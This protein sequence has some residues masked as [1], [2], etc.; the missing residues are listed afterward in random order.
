MMERADD[1][2]RVAKR[3]SDPELPSAVS[4]TA[5]YP[6]TP[7]NAVEAADL[8]R[9]MQ[10]AMTPTPLDGGNLTADAAERAADPEW[11]ES[12]LAPSSTLSRR[13][14]WGTSWQ[15]N[16][17]TEKQICKE[18]E[19]ILTEHH[20]QSQSGRREAKKQ[21]MHRAAS[22]AGSTEFISPHGHHPT[23]RTKF[24]N[25]SPMCSY[26]TW[27]KR[28]DRRRVCEY[29]V[30]SNGSG[31]GEGSL[32]CSRELSRSTGC[33]DMRPT[34]LK[35]HN[36]PAKELL[37]DGSFKLKGVKPVAINQYRDFDPYS[38]ENRRAREAYK[39]A[40]HQE[41]GLTSQVAWSALHSWQ[42]SEKPFGSWYTDVQGGQKY[43]REVPRGSTKY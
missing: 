39:A 23:G 43:R 20:K 42:A 29:S 13:A 11:P 19:I 6:T 27:A 14:K 16:F 26:M 8:G 32:E 18:V 37:P 41:H 2:L 9:S 24:G 4:E 22:E 35:R 1:D 3:P 5:E 17:A 30:T 36:E 34:F 25:R 40:R 21:A 7:R 15:P 10:R 28:P 12:P 38:R 33:L 31:Y